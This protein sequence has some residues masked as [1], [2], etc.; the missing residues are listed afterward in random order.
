MD[1]SA[2]EAPDL[3][4]NHHMG[5]MHSRLGHMG[6][7]G[8]FGSIFGPFL[9]ESARD[10]FGVETVITSHMSDLFEEIM[11]GPRISN[12]LGF[13]DGAVGTAAARM[14]ALLPGRPLTVAQLADT[15]SIP[16]LLPPFLRGPREASKRP[17]VF[18]VTIMSSPTRDDDSD[19]S[20]QPTWRQEVV[21]SSSDPSQLQELAGMFTQQLQGLGSFAGLGRKLKSALGSVGPAEMAQVLLLAARK[22]QEAQALPAAQR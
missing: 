1:A 14:P 11:S 2:A 15:D 18:E 9:S 3:P 20:S 22:L 21:I 7:L 19:E 16:T 6:H 4:C 13:L 8:S 5:H 12:V 17:Q 10:V